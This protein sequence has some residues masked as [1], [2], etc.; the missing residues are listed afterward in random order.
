MK[1]YE[2]VIEEGWYIG[3]VKK[4]EEV[5]GKYGNSVKVTIVLDTTP[6]LEKYLFLPVY[7][8]ENNKTGKFLRV[9]GI[10]LNEDEVELE[11]CIGKK[12]AVYISNVKQGNKVIAKITDFAPAVEEKEVE[13]KIEKVKRVFKNAKIEKEG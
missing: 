2:Y 7:F 9:V 3:K 11:G 1:R 10:S 12:I 8:T 13:E 4:V 5:E 6:T